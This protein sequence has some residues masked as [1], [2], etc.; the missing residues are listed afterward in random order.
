MA[1]KGRSGSFPQKKFNSRPRAV[2]NC[3]FDQKGADS[4]HSQNRNSITGPE[5][6]KIANLSSKRLPAKIWPKRAVPAH[7]HKRNS[8]AGPGPSKMANL[9]SKRLPARIWPKKAVFGSCLEKKFNSRSRTV[10]NRKFQFQELQEL[11]LIFGGC[12]AA[13]GRT[14]GHSP[15]A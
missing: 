10:Q 3:K 2:Q 4:A 14:G 9:S 7:S 5:P 15:Q 1:Q 13:A 12:R 6:S 8:I 11:G